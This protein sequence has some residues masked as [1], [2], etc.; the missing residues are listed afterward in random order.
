MREIGHSEIKARASG[1]GERSRAWESVMGG[2]KKL[3]LGS[4]YWEY[5]E[6]YVLREGRCVGVW[7]YLFCEDGVTLIKEYFEDWEFSGGFVVC[8]FL[9]ECSA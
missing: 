1:M 3:C 7:R 5:F 4:P 2:L 6:I 8:Y 9:R